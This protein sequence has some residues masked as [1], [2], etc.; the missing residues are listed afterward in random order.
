MTRL[1]LALAIGSL[2]GCTGVYPVGPLANSGIGSRPPKPKSND[3]DEAPE[4]VVVPAVK[5][6]PPLNTTGPEDVNPDDPHAALR[7]LKQ[8]LEADRN[9]IPTAPKTAEVSRYKGGVKQ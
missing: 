3:K 4:P 6:T 7:K 1:L 5:P 9:T 2:I 8:E